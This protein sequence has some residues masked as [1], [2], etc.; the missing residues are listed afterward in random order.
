MKLLGFLLLAAGFLLGAY[1]TALDTD[2]TNWSLFVPAAIGALVGV[3]LIK[4]S[5]RGEARADHVLTANRSELLESLTN[6]IATLDDMSGSEAS[7]ATDDIRNQVDSRLREDLRRF[8]DARESMVHLFGLQVY[9][10]VM[11]AFAAGERYVNRVWSASADGYRH[12]AVTYLQK[13]ADQFRDADQQLSVAA[14]AG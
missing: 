7:I 13:A 14:N 3:F 4:R 9:A 5:S 10:D 1:S 12:E 8:A 6:I 2:A 11:S